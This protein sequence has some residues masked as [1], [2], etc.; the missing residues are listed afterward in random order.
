MTSCP[1]YTYGKATG[2]KKRS[3]AAPTWSNGLAP[4]S[5]AVGSPGRPLYQRPS[6]LV[7]P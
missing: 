3:S 4:K 7:S 2:K 5:T 1:A 6:W